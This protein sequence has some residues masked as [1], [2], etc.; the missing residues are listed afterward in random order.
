MEST[1]IKI[2]H[3]LKTIREAQGYSLSEIADKVGKS[4]KTIHAYEKGTIGIS[5][6]NLQNILKIYN[7]NVGRFLDNIECK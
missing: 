5:V 4:R 3:S 2:G 1:N 6:S 7:V